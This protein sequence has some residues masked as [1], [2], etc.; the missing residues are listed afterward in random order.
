MK[1][2]EECISETLL[3]RQNCI[4]R[5]NHLVKRRA[6]GVNPS[7]EYW[8]CY[9]TSWTHYLTSLSPSFYICKT[10]IRGTTLWDALRFK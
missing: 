3:V 10:G 5:L 4:K 1:L 6:S 8:F 7:F 2:R 9:L